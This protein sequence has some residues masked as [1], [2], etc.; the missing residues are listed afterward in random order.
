ME[1]MVQYQIKYCGETYD[2]FDRTKAEALLSALFKGNKEKIDLFLSSKNFI[3]AKSVDESKAA[4]IDSKFKAVGIKLHCIDISQSTTTASDN[5]NSKKIS[6]ALNNSY[7]ILKKIRSVVMNDTAISVS[8]K[9]EWGLYLT[10]LSALFGSFWLA[11][12]YDRWFFDKSI[13]FNFPGKTN[14]IVGLILCMP[15]YVRGFIEFKHISIYR[16]VVFLLNW[17]LCAT[18]CQIILGKENSTV[19]DATAFCLFGGI[20]LTWLG[21]RSVAGFCWL[22]FIVIAL[23]NLTFNSDLPGPTGFL[24]LACGFFSLMFQLDLVPAEMYYKFKEEFKGIDPK[25][26]ETIREDVSSA[27]E[28]V[29]AATIAAAKMAAKSTVG[30]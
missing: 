21:I 6:T 26:I 20:L 16:C 29:S 7:S 9:K 22:F 30:G 3:I 2:Y 24:F 23:L 25:T 13:S 28:K 18:I 11:P 27:A 5:S 8:S 4:L 14:G 19:N 12:W 17:L 10:L 15:L 1:P